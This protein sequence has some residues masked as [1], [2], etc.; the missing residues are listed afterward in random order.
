[1]RSTIQTSW[2]SVSLPSVREQ[3]AKMGFKIV[4]NTPE[5]FAVFLR[6]E[7]IKWGKV[8]KDLGLRAE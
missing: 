8:V 6:E 7:N 1:M 3:L 4:A 2:Q 5:Q